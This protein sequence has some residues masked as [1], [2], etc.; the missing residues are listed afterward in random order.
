MVDHLPW[1]MFC[2]GVAKDKTYFIQKVVSLDG[3][4]HLRVIDA[5]PQRI[6]NRE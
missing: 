1:T 3:T 6:A 4:I 2:R 5:V